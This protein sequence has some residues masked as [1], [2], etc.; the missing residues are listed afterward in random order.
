MTTADGQRLEADIAI[1]DEAH[2]GG[3]VVCHPHPLYGGTRFNP[4]VDE[5]FAALPAAGFGTLRFDFRRGPGDGVAERLDVE[6]AIDELARHVGDGPIDLA[7]YSFGAAVA[8]GARDN[9]IGAIAAI[10][11]PLGM[12]AVEPPL[13]PTFVL[14]PAHDQFCP[15]SDAEPVV[16]GW[17]N[18]TSE[19]VESTD[20]F[21]GGRTRWI[22]DRVTAWL[23][24]ARDDLR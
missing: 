11:P 20:H 5:L 8:L 21:L 16:G 7:G 22:A 15:P 19:V 12:V 24:R 18:A 13:V 4:M 23:M 9:R 3:V 10:A 1:P 14:V 6:A 2:P 17:P